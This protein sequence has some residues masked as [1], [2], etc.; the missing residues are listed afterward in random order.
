ML[1][2]TQLNVYGI[3]VHWKKYTSEVF[4]AK[5]VF[6]IPYTA[7]FYSVFS[8]KVTQP[9][10]SLLASRRFVWRSKELEG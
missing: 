10:R 9:N 6:Y 2:L 8:L 7:G 5:I 3:K 4:T 1:H